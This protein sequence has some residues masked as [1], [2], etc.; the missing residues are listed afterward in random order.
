MI[1]VKE[2][3]INYYWEISTVIFIDETENFRKEPRIHSLL[4]NVRCEQEMDF[5]DY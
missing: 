2:V 5:N 3:K 4:G 1:F